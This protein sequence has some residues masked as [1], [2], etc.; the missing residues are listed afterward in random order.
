[1]FLSDTKI[2]EQTDINMTKP[3]TERHGNLKKKKKS[4]TG[5]AVRGWSEF[6]A[7]EIK[8]KGAVCR[9]G[10]RPAMLHNRMATH[11]TGVL[12]GSNL[13]SYLKSLNSHRSPK[14]VKGRG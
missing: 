1:M 8:D 14:I 13:L 3:N 4:Q 9:W 11:R 7:K 6:L 5:L 2:T 10:K 12:Q